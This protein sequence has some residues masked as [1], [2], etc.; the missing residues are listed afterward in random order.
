[1][2]FDWMVMSVYDPFLL[3]VEPTPDLKAKHETK[4]VCTLPRDSQTANFT[5]RPL[6]P[7]CLFR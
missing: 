2:V 3:S 4:E 6:N 7:R 5:E 1:M